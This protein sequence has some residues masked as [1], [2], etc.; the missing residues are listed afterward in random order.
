MLDDPR[1]PTHFWNK[2]EPEPMTG[3][4]LWNG[5]INNGYGRVWLGGKAPLLVHRVAYSV[6][7]GPIPEG[8]TIDHLCRQPSCV[9][10]AHLE[11][12]TQRENLLRGET[13][14]AH[15]AR[16]THCSRGHEFTP[17]NTALRKDKNGCLCRR[18]R[19]CER[20]H[21]AVRGRRIQAD[22]KKRERRNRYL[23]EW[24]AKQG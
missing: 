8:L 13:I 18:C 15:N 23:R 12:V 5:S 3:C 6:L 7:V 19:Q 24:R 22:P 20:A 9:N 21:A 4:W 11:P 1:L 14:A 2:V 17:E 16:K 10:P